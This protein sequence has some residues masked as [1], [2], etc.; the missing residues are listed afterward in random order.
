MKNVNIMGVWG[1]GGRGGRLI[2]ID[3]GGVFE[4]C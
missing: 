3:G 1:G 2:K 4:G